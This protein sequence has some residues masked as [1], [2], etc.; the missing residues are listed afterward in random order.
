[1]YYTVVYPIEDKPYIKECQK[2]LSISDMCDI[3]AGF[4][5]ITHPEHRLRALIDCT[6]T[7]LIEKK[8]VSFYIYGSDPD[9]HRDMYYGLDKKT[10][11]YILHK[12]ML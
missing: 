1:M 9:I 2:H 4:Y 10:A 5:G 7:E 8:P 12:S 3:S 6:V 11:E